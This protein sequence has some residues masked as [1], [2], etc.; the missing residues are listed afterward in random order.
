ML[1]ETRSH[2]PP[3]CANHPWLIT[4]FADSHSLAYLVAPQED[5]SACCQLD[6]TKGFPYSLNSPLIE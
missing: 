6:V 3:G 2:G 5:A 4:W 1:W